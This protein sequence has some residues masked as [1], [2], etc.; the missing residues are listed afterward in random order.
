MLE[1]TTMIINFNRINEFSA[2]INELAGSQM[3]AF[4]HGGTILV[5]VILLVTALLVIVSDIITKSKT[6]EVEDEEIIE[7]LSAEDCDLQS[8]LD[9]NVQVFNR[10][11][12]GRW[13]SRRQMKVQAK[14]EHYGAEIHE[15][16]TTSYNTTHE[17]E[18]CCFDNGEVN[19]MLSFVVFAQNKMES[20]AFNLIGLA[21]TRTVQ[22]GL[23][24]MA[25]MALAYVMPVCSFVDD[26]V[27]MPQTVKELKAENE[28]L[29]AK[30]E[31][32]SHDHK[33]ITSSVRT[34]RVLTQ[35]MI[36]AMDPTDC[37]D[38]ENLV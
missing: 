5:G 33:V 19:P 35:A 32:L 4:A 2:I 31:G 11:Q 22:H 12:S 9:G 16:E 13:Y 36:L 34:N 37:P 20:V 8:Y 15:V 24:A 26:M 17:V 25:A 10:A 29:L 28:A 14:V 3:E 27:A 18:E 23:I 1:D 30:I 38:R 6:Y 7:C 21:N